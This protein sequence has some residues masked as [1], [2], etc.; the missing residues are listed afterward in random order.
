V[1]ADLPG[2][3]L[4]TKRTAASTDPQLTIYSAG[5]GYLNAAVFDVL[6]DCPAVRAFVDVDGQQVAFQ[7]APE[8][9]DHAYAIDRESDTAGGDVRLK[10]VLD[11][12]GVDPDELEESYFVAL[13]RHDQRD[14][15]LVGD[16]SDL[17]VLDDVVS[18]T[19]VTKLEADDEDADEAVADVDDSNQPTPGPEATA[20]AADTDGVSEEV[21][22]TASPGEVD[23]PDHS[24]PEPDNMPAIE[25]TSKTVTEK[26]RELF[27]QVVP[28]DGSIKLT[29]GDIAGRIDEDGR[30]V[31][32]AFR[33]L[34]DEYDIE[35]TDEETDTGAS[36]WAIAHLVDEG[37]ATDDAAEDSESEAEDDAGDG[38]TERKIDRG[39][40][41][42]V[43]YWCGFCG[44]GPFIRE[45]MVEGHHDRNGHPGEPVPRTEDPAHT[46]EDYDE[47]IVDD[48][49]TPEERV[50]DWL[51]EHV[52]ETQYFKTEDVA[53]EC[54]ISGNNAHDTLEQVDI[55]GYVIESDGRLW[56]I[57]A[58][59]GG[60]A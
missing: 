38:P 47:P 20:E 19:A 34:S 35:Q 36:I 9:T 22:E 41:P 30:G 40:D 37:P 44:Q 18:E 5:N 58:P 15:V 51:V 17:H 50:H 25:D 13:E 4:V 28:E 31:P 42:E 55:D 59:T 3:Q 57:R 12:L 21:P 2:F 60:D 16:V 32:A 24:S 54:D 29:C 1:S 8:V 27:E 6:G 45:D 43:Q 14:D 46:L 26:T 48:D 39:D 23:L 52:P 56:R 11:D 49:R 7:A 10:S 33:S 53:V